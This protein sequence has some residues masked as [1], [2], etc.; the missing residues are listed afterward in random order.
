[1]DK[2]PCTRVSSPLAGT[3]FTLVHSLG[4]GAWGNVSLARTTPAALEEI[5]PELPP[6]VAI[7]L[8]KKC[9]KITTCHCK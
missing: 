1:M 5:S 8:I 4:F 6:M 7:K 3:Y 2:L 9:C